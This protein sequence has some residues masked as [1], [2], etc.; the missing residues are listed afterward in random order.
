MR[1]PTLSRIKPEKFF[2]IGAFL[3]LNN[4]TACKEGEFSQM[5]NLSSKSFPAMSPISDWAVFDNE[6]ADFFLYENNIF[7]IDKNGNFYKNSKLI[8]SGF[9]SDIHEFSV[10]GKYLI[11]MPDKLYYDMENGTLGSLEASWTGTGYF[12]NGSDTLYDL[13]KTEGNLSP[14][15][16]QGDCVNIV[17]D[18][19]DKGYFYISDLKNGEAILENADFSDIMSECNLCISRKIPD[20]INTFECNNRLWGTCEDVIY[21][22]SLGD[23]FNFYK[24]RGISTDSYFKEIYSAG[25]FTS[26]I[27]YGETPLFF[28]ENGIYRV[29][30]NA[31]DDFVVDVKEAPGVSF[32]CRYSAVNLGG[33]VYYAAADGIYLYTSAYPVKISNDLGDLKIGTA[34]GGSDGKKYYI[35]F[36]EFHGIKEDLSEVLGDYHSYNFYC[37]DS[38]KGCWYK[39]DNALRINKVMTGAYGSIFPKPN[40]LAL[41]NDGRLIGISDKLAGSTWD[42]FSND[43]KIE[44]NSMGISGIIDFGATSRINSIRIMLKAFSNTEFTGEISFDGG[45]FETFCNIKGGNGEFMKHCFRV[46]RKRFSYCRLRFC[47]KGDFILSSVD[48]YY[49]YSHN[50]EK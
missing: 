41:D 36:S 18:G 33:G 28:K 37:F 3:G 12:T 48:L 47:A 22:S 13:L 35:S 27:A 26:G 15:F 8:S 43:A 4:T 46:K 49:T 40:T 32:D 23:P 20:I 39:Y 2:H 44:T 45:D 38:E 6:V 24:Y 1:L 9:D 50:K 34:C 42:R 30:G 5:K 21:A 14:I 11:I 16:R 31:P 25:G 19:T 7:K 10:I 17:V 29:Y